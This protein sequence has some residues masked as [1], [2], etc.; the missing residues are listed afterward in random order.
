MI[1]DLQK[2]S[3]DPYKV[4]IISLLLLVLINFSYMGGFNILLSVSLVVL[5]SVLTDSI[6]GYVRLKRL[7]VSE[8]ALISGLVLSL[9]LSPQAPI[10][11]LVLAPA[12]AQLSKHVIRYKNK[13]VFNPATFGIFL[14]LLAYPAG[15]AWWGNT[16][17]IATVILGLLVSYRIM[18][19]YASGAFL[20]GIL[21]FSILKDVLAGVSIS[22]GSYVPLVLSQAFL[23][24]F[25]MVEPKSSTNKIEGQLLCGLTAAA[26]AIFGFAFGLPAPLFLGLLT[27]NLVATFFK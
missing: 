12:I 23:G 20:S 13:P 22:L 24:L 10:I 5:V 15:E 2:M 17:I 18:R 3:K 16:T 8:T 6:I 21:I 9:V 4:I 1:P 26:V 14:V 25:M 11:Y 7:Y 27:A 19:L